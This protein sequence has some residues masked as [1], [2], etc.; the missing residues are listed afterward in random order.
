MFFSD[1]TVR[2]FFRTEISLCALLIISCAGPIKEFYPD[3]YFVE[4][5]VY[6]N[7]PIGFSLTF[8]GNWELVTEPSRMEKGSRS[9][10]RTLQESGA[11]LLFVGTTFEKTQG[12]R[13]IA[14]NL[15]VPCEEYA[16]N[17]RVINA[18]DVTTDFG[19]TVHEL[20]GKPLVRWD[21][22]VGEYRFAEYFYLLDTYDIRIAFWTKPAIFERFDPVYRKIIESISFIGRL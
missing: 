15:N 3:S 6:Q 17:I 8:S 16:E 10:A 11:D 18:R 5:G 12:V 19:L 2:T 13:G 14:I 22:V 21:Y 7:R 9:F 1:T 4:D 20:H